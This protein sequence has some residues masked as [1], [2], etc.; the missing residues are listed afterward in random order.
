MEPIV[1]KIFL[2][3]FLCLTGLVK[4]DYIPPTL[5]ELILKSDKIIYGEIV[6]VDDSV[7]EVYVHC[8]IDYGLETITIIKFDEWDCGK[9]WAAY[10]V[11]E[12]SLFFLTNKNGGY[13]TM[14]GGNEGELPIL[15]DKCYM[16]ASTISKIGFID[17][18]DRS[19]L[20]REDYG[21]NNPFNGY[22]LDFVDLWQ[23]IDLIK[24]CFT[25]EKTA[26]GRLT[27]IQRLCSVNE[28]EAPKLHN[29]VLEWAI[30]KLTNEAK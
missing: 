9:R 27:D 18:F 19:N 21:F 6:C 12:N 28:L 17:K 15:K 10:K 3:L 4:A 24:G 16:H 5:N 8:G 20:T 2:P 25:A 13:L 11:G 30:N 1:K 29:S 14:G 23:T 7:I 26:S 22:V